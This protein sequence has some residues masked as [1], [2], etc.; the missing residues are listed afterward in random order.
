MFLIDSDLQV[1]NALL[2]IRPSS[3]GFIEQNLKVC[4]LI[5]TF[6]LLNL[7]SLSALA[8]HVPVAERLN[9]PPIKDF[10][11]ICFDYHTAF[12]NTD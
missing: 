5:P 9:R 12:K 6:R 2:S 3:R 4:V 10:P 1:G 11:T 8:R 7:I